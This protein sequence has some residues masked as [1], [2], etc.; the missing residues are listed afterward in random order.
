MLAK[1]RNGCFGDHDL[2]EDLRHR[3]LDYPL[4]REIA[5]KSSFNER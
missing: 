4:N 5:L 2:S 1:L 3:S